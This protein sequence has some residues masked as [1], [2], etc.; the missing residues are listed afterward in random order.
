[1]TRHVANGMVVLT[2][3]ARGID[4]VD[5]VEARRACAVRHR[6]DLAGLSLAVEKCPADPVVALV[7]DRAASVPELG[8]A[9]LAPDFLL[10]T[11]T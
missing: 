7:A 2:Q 10:L 1:M 5:A 8:C 3:T 4:H 6:R 9:D 11:G